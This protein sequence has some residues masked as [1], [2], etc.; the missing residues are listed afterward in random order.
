MNNNIVTTD[1]KAVAA[2][3]AFGLAEITEADAP[4]V[5]E[6]AAR[7]DDR[8]PMTVSEFGR[9]VSEH[10]SKYADSLLDQVRNSDLNEAGAKLTEVVVV[11]RKLNMNALTDRRSRIP[12]IGPLIDRFSVSVDG[13]KSQFQTTKTQIE[14]LVG[15]V[16]ESQKGLATRNNILEDMFVHVVEE[17]RLLGLHIAAGKHRLEELRNKATLMRESGDS[18]ALAAQELSDLES[19]IS[20]LDKRVGDLLVLQQSA[21]QSLPMIRMIQSNNKM[22]IDKFHTIREVTV[23]S[24]KNQFMLA[25]S[26][27]EQRNAVELVDNIDNA[28]KE[29]LER[30]AKLL[31][32]NSVQAAKANQR[33]A[34]DVETLQKVQNSL[35]ATVEEVIKI[36]EEG[37]AK[38][39]DAEKEIATMRQELYTRLARIKGKEVA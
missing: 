9:E 8:N 26:L 37:A 25:L 6:I 33:L 22:L 21:V 1:Q 19:L 16:N 23:P 32:Q 11:A 29:I 12:I 7:I 31:H 14:T 38:R 20:N 36:R 5:M 18:S 35:I 17:Y 28:T 4:K 34:I 2:Q 15:E 3:L 24:W 30:N 10:T 27:N 13:F 39:A